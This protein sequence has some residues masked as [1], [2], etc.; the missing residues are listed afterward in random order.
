MEERCKSNNI[1]IGSFLTESTEFIKHIFLGLWLTNI[2]SHL[3]FF[4][5]P[6]IGQ[7][8][9][10]VHRIPD[11]KSQKADCIS[12]VWDGIMDRDFACFF[13]IIPIGNNCVC[14]T[15]DNF[16][17]AMDIID[18]I[19]LELV[20]IKM[21]HDADRKL[22]VFGGN[23]ITHQIHLLDLIRIRL[24]PFIIFSSC[25]I[26]SVLFDVHITQFFRHVRAVTIANC[27]RF[28]TIDDIY[29]R[30]NYVYICWYCNSSCIAHF[31]VPFTVSINFRK[32]LFPISS[33]GN[34]PQ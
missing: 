3:M 17:P 10:H 20:G 8:V 16:P 14:S 2:I 23:K 19:W 6:F 9:I 22:G 34:T 27:I 28:P 33:N 4:A 29:G 26:S 25:V 5:F 1:D 31:N 12:M 30:I 13:I 11:H 24:C 32:A 15:I 21:F 7:A 18:R